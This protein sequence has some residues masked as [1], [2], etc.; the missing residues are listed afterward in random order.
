M[1]RGAGKRIDTVAV[2]GSSP[3]APTNIPIPINKFGFVLHESKKVVD[4]NPTSE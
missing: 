3:H 2:W 4:N 1:A